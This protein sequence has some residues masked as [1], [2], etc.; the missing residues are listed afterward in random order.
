MTKKLNISPWLTLTAGLGVGL[1]MG[2]GMLIGALVTMRGEPQLV[3]P[4]TAL[5]A[6]ATHG[7]DSFAIA[8]G[9]ISDGVEGIFFL[10]YLTGEVQCWVLNPRTGFLGGRYRHNVVADLGVEQGKKPNYIMVTGAASFRA[11][12]AA[13]RPAD[14]LLYVVDGN[15]GRFAAYSLPWNRNAAATNTPQS[16]PF[17][18]IGKG[19]IRNVEIR[20]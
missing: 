6:T 19:A 13:V 12:G 20:E 2:V 5:H 1:L 16:F 8:T 4:E 9:Q 3:L 14:S 15:T 11:G 18:L 17:K 7:S 10:D